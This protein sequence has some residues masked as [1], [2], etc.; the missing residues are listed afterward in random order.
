MRGAI[1][2]PEG[3]RV[4]DYAILSV[5]PGGEG[6]TVAVVMAIPGTVESENGSRSVGRV[7]LHLMVEQYADLI[8]AGISLRPGEL[9]REQADTLLTA[10]KL[11]AAIRRGMMVLQ[12]GDCSARRLIYKLTTKGVK[13]E[14][15]EAAA[16][17]LSEKGYLR[18]DDAARRR[19]EQ[20]IRKGWGIRR[21]RDDLRAQ[22]FSAEAVEEALGVLDEVDLPTRC[23]EVIRKKYGSI[24]T[25]KLERK[26]MVAALMRQGYGMDEIR[27]A[28]EL[29]S[30]EA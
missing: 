7:K 18:E 16:A 12:Y 5:T 29:V 2:A 27:E 17:Y 10:G 15:A 4:G 8:S 9:T 11:C 25:D 24:P 26:K 28:V 13:R 1:R 14:I 22:G 20:G 3:T 21:I 30:R 23:A 6:E 19:A